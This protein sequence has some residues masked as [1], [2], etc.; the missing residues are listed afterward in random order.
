MSSIWNNGLNIS[1]FGESHGKAIGVVIDN[2]PPGFKIDIDN[3]NNFMKRRT[4][5]YNIETSTKR[6][7]SDIPNIISGIFNDKTTGAPITAIIENNDKIS[8]NYDNIK[9][10]P[11]P[12]HSDYTYYKKYKG[13]NDYR[14]GGHSSGRLTAGIVFAGAICS[15]ILKKYNIY[16]GAHIKSIKDIK[17]SLLNPTNI[18]LSD[19]EKIKSNVFPVINKHIEKDMKHIIN[20]AKEDN[21]SLGG[22]IECAIIGVPCGIGSPIF[23]NLKSVISSLI[24]SIPAVKGLEFGNGFNSTLLT[25]YENNDEFIINDNKIKTLTNNHGGILG[26]ISSGMPIIFNV[27]FKPTSSIYKSQKTINIKKFKNDQIKIEGRHDP[28]IVPRAVPVVEA[29]GY[30]AITSELIKSNFFS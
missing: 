10:T 28:C 21:N 13:N 25:G 29:A 27:A 23:K 26:G 7:E 17:D 12:G 20:K 15:E 30:I 22:I 24:F 16:C 3:I 14:G 18:S 5:I 6:K 1:L 4:S 11:R 9:Y 2:A 19:F 8:H